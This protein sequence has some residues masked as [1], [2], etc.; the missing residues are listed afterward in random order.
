MR[1]IFA[2]GLGQPVGFV[3]PIERGQ[4]K[5]GPEWQSAMWM[6]RARHLFL[7]PGDSPVGL[8]L[9]LDRPALGARRRAAEGLDR[10]IP[11]RP[12]GR[13]RCP[14]ACTRQAMQAGFRCARHAPKPARR[15]PRRPGPLVRTALTV[16]PRDGRLY[17][18]LP[19]P[20]PRRISWSCSRRSRIPRRIPRNA[21]P[22]RGLFAAA[23][24]R[25][26]PTSR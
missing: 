16:T 24:Y 23:R 21:G 11:W 7:V 26:C 22:D 17:V 18:F 13:C 25:A 4:G 3:L 19:P 2:R 12:S 1:R 6:L 14:S 9:P 10:W 8:R 5:S 15:R 20:N